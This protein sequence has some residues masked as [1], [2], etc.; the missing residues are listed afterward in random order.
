MGRK[1][2]AIGRGWGIL[3]LPVWETGQEDDDMKR[4]LLLG[5]LLLAALAAP[6]PA[7]TVEG[8]LVDKACSTEAT[9]AEAAK[10]HTKDCALMPACASS[11]YG[12]LTDDGRFLKFDEDG[13]RMAAKMLSIESRKDNLRFSVSGTIEGGTIRVI[14]IQIV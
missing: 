9:S 14:A 2:W 12:L 13:D 11:G 3:H 10:A 5:C 6:L 7:E 8:Y 4:L 1:D